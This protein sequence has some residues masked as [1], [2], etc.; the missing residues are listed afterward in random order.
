[1]RIPSKSDEAEGKPIKLSFLLTA[2]QAGPFPVSSETL[3][4]QPIGMNYRVRN[5]PFFIDKVSLDDT[6]SVFQLPN[7][8]FE[9][10]AVIVPSANSTIWLCCINRPVHRSSVG[11]D[12]GRQG[13]GAQ[14]PR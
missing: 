12:P 9:I 13:A 4:C 7:G 6:I 8:F 1:M 14:P 10:N 5:I 2:E 11:P 3:W